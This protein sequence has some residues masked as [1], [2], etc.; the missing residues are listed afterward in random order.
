MKKANIKITVA[1]HL[2]CAAAIKKLFHKIL[3]D[4]CRRFK[5]KVLPGA[6]QI[7]VVTAGYAPEDGSEGVM[8]RQDNV[9]IIQLNDPYMTEVPHNDILDFVFVVAMCHEFVHA[10]QQL[11]GRTGLKLESWRLDDSEDVLS[12][13][14]FFD[15]EE[16]EARILDEMYARYCPPIIYTKLK[17][18]GSIGE[19]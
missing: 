7:N 19:S 4:Y 6:W 8:T 5:V 2:K 11:T 14:Y 10:C 13:E 12:E 3:L 17:E 15:P 18:A 1:T 9:I 16:I